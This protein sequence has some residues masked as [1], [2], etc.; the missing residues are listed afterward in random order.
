MAEFSS[1]QSAVNWI[2]TELLES[3]EMTIIVPV[4][5]PEAA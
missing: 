5:L 4:P 1:V 2:M 3:H